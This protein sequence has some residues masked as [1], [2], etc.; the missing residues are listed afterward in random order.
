MTAAGANHVV[1]NISYEDIWLCTDKPVLCESLQ[2]GNP[3]DQRFPNCGP[4]T[5]G[6]P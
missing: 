4:R 3:I 5:P 1:L 2:D 6:G